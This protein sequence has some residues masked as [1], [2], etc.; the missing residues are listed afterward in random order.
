MTTDAQPT[1]P[2]QPRRPDRR[3]WWIAGVAVLI[4]IAAVITLI[5]VLTGEKEHVVDEA[6][7]R[8]AREAQG[9]TFSDWRLYA[10]TVVNDV[11]T[12]EDFG[13]YVA[14]RLD[15]GITETELRTDFTYACPSR[16]PD[17]EQELRDIED[18]CAGMDAEERA[19]F[20]E[21]AGSPC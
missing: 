9:T 3:A 16:V 21:A 1:Q 17:F 4:A 7:W 19:L 10:D 13:Y 18:P 20:E 5:V 11:C 12:D 15:D 2:T 8:E 6:A 14:L